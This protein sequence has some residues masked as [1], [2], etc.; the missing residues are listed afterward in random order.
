MKCRGGRAPNNVKTR[1]EPK[2]FEKDPEHLAQIAKRKHGVLKHEKAILDEKEANDKDLSSAKYSQR[3]K[4]GQV[5]STELAQAQVMT[6]VSPFCNTRNE[7]ATD[8]G[9]G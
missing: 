6:E 7:K 1:P 9:F 3:A 8:C 4:L 2:L 5:G